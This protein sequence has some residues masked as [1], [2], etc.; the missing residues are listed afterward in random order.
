M[1]G[2]LPEVEGDCKVKSYRQE[3]ATGV[4][5]RGINSG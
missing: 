5:E 2:Q 1:S 3:I 4:S